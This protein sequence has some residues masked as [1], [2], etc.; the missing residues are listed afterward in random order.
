[1]NCVILQAAGWFR[2]HSEENRI[3]WEKWS[4]HHSEESRI[5]WEQWSPHHSEEKTMIEWVKWSRH[6]SEE[7][8]IEWEKHLL[9]TQ[10]RLGLSGKSGLVIT[11][12]RT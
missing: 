7:N 9:I 1:M 3:E 11:Q 2:H 5:E 8:M 12:K 10:K 6:H 4:P